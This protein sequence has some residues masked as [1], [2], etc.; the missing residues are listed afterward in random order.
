MHIV[1]RIM[2]VAGPRHR[3]RALEQPRSVQAM[4]MAGSLG[5]V[6]KPSIDDDDDLLDV[7]HGSDLDDDGLGVADAEEL[8]FNELEDAP[9]DV[10]LDTESLAGSEGLPA[11]DSDDE[12]E[13]RSADDDAPLEIEHEIDA[14]GEE[15]GWTREN[16]GSSEGWDDELDE[17]FDDDFDKD[18]GEEGVD[19]PL[20]DGLPDDAFPRAQLGDDDDEDD[21][22]DW[23]DDLPPDLRQDA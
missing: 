18:A 22:E 13:D 4:V 20:L 19:D 9:E 21:E 3:Y 2:A 15:G 8:L 10:G 1:V 12:A 16:E 14:D 23:L 11:I 6:G 17:E 7:P 5:S